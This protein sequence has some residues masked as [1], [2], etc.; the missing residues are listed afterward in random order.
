[1]SDRRVTLVLVD[2]AGRLLGALP[3]FGVGLPYWPETAEIVDQARTRFGLDVAV[4]RILATEREVPHGGGVTYLAQTDQA[5][6]DA[7][8]RL[9][10]PPIE[11]DLSPHL[12]RAPYAEPGGPAA[13]LRW[14]QA[15]LAGRGDGP[16]LGVVQQRTWN[17]SAIWRLHTPRGP[18][19][20]KQVPRFFG[21]EPAVLSWLAGNGFGASAPRLLGHDDGR[22]LLE[23]IPGEDLYGAPDA[24]RAAIA[25]VLHP[26][27]VRA[28][29]RVDELRAAGVPDHRAPELIRLCSDVV[30][31]HGG[32]RARLRA[33]AAG[34][35]ERLNRVAACALPDT[36][37]HGDLHPGNV[38]GEVA[39][40]PRII[41]DWGDASIG[42]PAFDILRLSE[43][44][45]APAALLTEWA[46]RWRSTVAGCDPATAVELLRPVAALRAAATYAAF[47]DQIEPTEHA[48]HAADVPT[49]L[50]RA[51]AL[52]S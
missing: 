41:I 6:A 34:L 25:A 12:L 31:R 24:V 35:G 47:L 16:V 7:R 23:H 36:L 14:A 2:A 1:V 50:A 38:R 29:G 52:A 42:H 45:A 17:L 15:T 5:G 37:V 19:W 26:M 43:D 48:Y 8:S 27:Q 39:G 44:A 46:Q 3:A 4:L 21:H 20:L 51:A 30:A 33:L 49:W 11:I 13:S 32:G 9:G 10:P 18:V 28:A 22:M 40:G